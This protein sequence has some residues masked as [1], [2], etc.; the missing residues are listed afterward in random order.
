[1]RANRASVRWREMTETF[2][3]FLNSL[4]WRSQRAITRL[5]AG[6][7]EGAAAEHEIA[8]LN[9]RRHRDQMHRQ[10]VQSV[11]DAMEDSLS[12]LADGGFE[13]PLVFC[14]AEA[15]PRN[16]DAIFFAEI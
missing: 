1:M 5:T 8:R 4:C 15:K 10:S 6:S 13:G 7:D 16:V 11:L 14:S 3:V 2:E 12:H 9:P